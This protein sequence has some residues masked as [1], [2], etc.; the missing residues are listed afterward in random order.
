MKLFGSK[1]NDEDLN[2]DLDMA[3]MDTAEL[4]DGMDFDADASTDSLSAP[5]RDFEGLSGG[6]SRKGMLAGVLLLAVAGLGGGYYFLTSGAG[7]DVSL[8]QPMASAQVSTTPDAT[9]DLMGG[10]VPPMPDPMSDM[11]AAPVAAPVAMPGFDVPDDTAMPSDMAAMPADTTAILPSDTTAV[12]PSDATPAMPSD[13]AAVVDPFADL[14]MPPA[15]TEAEPAMPTGDIS[16][17]DAPIEVEAPGVDSAPV[18][19]AITDDLPLATEEPP[20]D[21][22]MTPSDTTAAPVDATAAAA[23]APPPE[24]LPMP[25][26]VEAVT[27]VVPAATD[28][29]VAAPPSNAEKAIVDNAAMLDQLSTPAQGTAADP[30][31]A[32]KTINEILGQPAVVRSLPDSYLVVRQDY[33][34]G[35]LETRLKAARIALMEGR[36]SASLQ[37]FNTL[38]QD[39]PRDERVT[40]GRAL[41]LQHMG[42]NIEALATYEQILGNNPKNLDALTN[43]LGLLKVQNPQLAIDKLADLHRAY[44]YN[45]DIA[46][47][48]GISYAGMRNFEEALRYLD[49]ADALKPQDASIMYNRAVL[50][51]HMGRADVAGPLYQR[52]VHMY[53]DGL[54]SDPL[55]IESIRQRLVTLSY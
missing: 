54:I 3:D 17:I 15:T 6:K 53:A 49:V 26:V 45:A 41:S 1:D 13:T 7:D 10:V 16:V 40:M 21:V 27:P 28:P 23:V 55:P 35:E 37:L 30:A 14:G 11:A 33:A 22:F 5:T 44:P 12:L 34:K 8:G 20:A 24:D 43:M 4:S 31:A 36:H 46:A 29:A 2:Q 38:S 32:G 50:Y 18:D 9:Q 39:Y 19:M 25:A 48:L 42:Q 47:Q 51:D 52:I